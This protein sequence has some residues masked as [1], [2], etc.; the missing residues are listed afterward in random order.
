MGRRRGAL[1]VLLAVLLAVVGVGLARIPSSGARASAHELLTA[2]DWYLARDTA[3]G[4]TN[5][6]NLAWVGGG[7]VPGSGT[8]YAEMVRV[9]LLD[10]RR[11]TAPN[12][13]VAAGA[14]GSWSYDWPR[15][16]AFVAVAMDRSGHREDAL[17]M[18]GFLAQMQAGDGGF[19]ARYKLDGSGVP[20]HRPRQADAPGW[21]LWALD[22][23][24]D[25]P[26]YAALPR[27][28][29]PDGTGLGLDGRTRRMADLSLARLL[30]D[31]RDGTRLPP[32]T[33]D[34]W[35]VPQSA[36]SL[37]EVAPMLAGMEA[38]TH[39]YSRLGDP[40]RAAAARRAAGRFGALVVRAFGPTFQRY[41][42]VGGRD[43]AVAM[44]MPPF[45]VSTPGYGTEPGES[46]RRIAAAWTAYQDN[47]ERPGGGL[48]PGEWWWRIGES[49]T[50]ETALVAYTAAASG[51]TVVARRWLDW[52]TA[53]RTPWGSMPEKVLP[54]GQP[55]G[56]A[57][58]AWTAALVVLTAYE[59]DHH[60]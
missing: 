48:A 42:E 14:A 17:R 43:A 54:E 25:D 44:L 4:R 40:A 47:A 12:G 53:H 51:R 10:L 32:V 8:R 35:E 57:P 9:A 49:W 56:P 38:A 21:V 11:L 27:G 46:G 18:L 13:A 16:T 45:V 39:L 55:A 41:R 50:P 26:G 30:G 33:P 2:P 28:R 59:L 58:L 34:Y 52:L 6:E 60:P 31:T 29:V 5:A 19:A 36:V 23:L 37:G 3:Y 22:Q 24:A 15:D 7:S 20:D 1:A